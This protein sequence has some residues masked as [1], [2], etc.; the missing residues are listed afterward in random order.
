MNS[1]M[2]Y[3][4]VMWLLQCIL[5]ESFLRQSNRENVHVA[6]IQEAKLMKCFPLHLRASG[7]PTHF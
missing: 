3:R 5:Y 2:T 4:G 1:E 6:I 7:R